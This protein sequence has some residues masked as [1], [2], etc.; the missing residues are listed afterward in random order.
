MGCGVLGGKRGD[1]NGGEAMEET[2]GDATE[3]IGG[4]ESGSGE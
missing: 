3:E 2:G 4:L 1:K